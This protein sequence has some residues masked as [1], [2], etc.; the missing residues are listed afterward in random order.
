MPHPG[1]NDLNVDGHGRWFAGEQMRGRAGAYQ[2]KL[3]ASLDSK[4]WQTV[5]DKT[6]NTAA[7]N[8]EFDDFKPAR[9]RWVRLTVTGA[10]PGARWGLLEYTIFGKSAGK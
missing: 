4:S 2:Y 6:G 8:V 7:N 10:P 1:A 3:E 5:V 9:A